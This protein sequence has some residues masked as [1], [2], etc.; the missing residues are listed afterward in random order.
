MIFYQNLNLIFHHQPYNIP[1]LCIYILH[2]SHYPLSIMKRI[3]YSTMLLSPNQGIWFYILSH[4]QIQE[5]YHQPILLHIYNHILS[6][7][8]CRMALR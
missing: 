7:Q 6:G 3:S 4:I 2:L 8:T 1:K 5:F